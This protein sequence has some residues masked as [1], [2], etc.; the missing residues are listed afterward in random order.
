MV[1]TAAHC[2]PGLAPSAVAARSRTGSTASRSEP[3]GSSWVPACRRTESTPPGAVSMTTRPVPPPE[4]WVAM[5]PRQSRYSPSARSMSETGTVSVEASGT[6]GNAACP[7][8][9]VAFSVCPTSRGR[10]ALG[11]RPS[12]CTPGDELRYGHPMLPRTLSAWAVVALALAAAGSAMAGGVG[13]PWYPNV[14][15]APASGT[16]D[17]THTYAV[18]GTRRT[19]TLTRGAKCVGAKLRG[20]V[21]HHGDLRKANL[22]RADLRFADLRGA[23]LAGADLRSANLTHADLRGANLK[24]AK[25]RYAA[26]VHRK[27]AK[28][29]N[30]YWLCGEASCAGATLNYANLGYTNLAGA[31]LQGADLVYAS[32][33][34]ANLT[35]A[36]L[37][38]AS[39]NYVT[40]NYATMTDATLT[41]AYMP[42]VNLTGANLTGATLTGANLSAVTWSNTTCPDG[43]VT[44][45][46]CAT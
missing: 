16:W 15:G 42:F 12:G 29:S 20:R 14:V 43:T 46:G 41:D 37:A 22:R 6:L 38:G 3:A 30:Q 32:L 21:K 18:N 7:D 25:F 39:L 40:A 33:Y 45:T 24:G 1:A 44:N 19:C 5:K 2:V 28:R 17:R 35:G 13:A 36:N 31:D 8:G 23:N 10:G 4:S 27:K 9:T 26:P 11:L 34:E